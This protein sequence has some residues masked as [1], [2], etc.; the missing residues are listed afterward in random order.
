M[1]SRRHSLFLS[2]LLLSFAYTSASARTRLAVDGNIDADVMPVLIAELE[3][4]DGQ[5]PRLHVSS[6]TNFLVQQE[7]ALYVESALAHHATALIE[8]PPLR[9]AVRGRYTVD[10][11]S[12]FD[13]SN[14]YEYLRGDWHADVVYTVIPAAF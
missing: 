1:S 10:V 8:G 11:T 3:L 12:M 6:N 4:V 2:F 14:A 5:D 13:A 7:A 9:T